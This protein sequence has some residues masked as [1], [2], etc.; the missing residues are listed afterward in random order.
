MERREV[1]R[2][3]TLSYIMETPRRAG[4]VGGISTIILN[5][6]IMIFLT[7]LFTTPI[8]VAAAIYLTEYARQ[9]RLIRIL[10]FGTETLRVSPPSSSGFSG[11]SL[12]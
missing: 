12:S 4:R 5:T 7:L 6:V 11:S 2:N 9:G 1:K 8:G 3:L 10:R